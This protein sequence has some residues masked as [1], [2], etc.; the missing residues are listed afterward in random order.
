MC[1]IRVSGDGIKCMSEKTMAG[2]GMTCNHFFGR[3][4]SFCV[5][6]DLLTAGYMERT[7]D[8]GSR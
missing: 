8:D 5:I 3:Y 7:V 4:T 1:R 6:R 2:Q